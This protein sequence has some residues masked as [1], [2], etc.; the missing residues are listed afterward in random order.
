MALR[1]CADHMAHDPRVITDF[2]AIPESCDKSHQRGLLFSQYRTAD[3]AR[4]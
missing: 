1:V 4:L 2:R 3:F